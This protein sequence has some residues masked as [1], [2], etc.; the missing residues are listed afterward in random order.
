M[1]SGS[2]Q[3]KF[4]AVT[5]LDCLSTYDAWLVKT[6]EHYGFTYHVFGQYGQHREPTRERSTF[7]LHEF[8]PSVVA[9]DQR[10]LRP[11][12][13]DKKDAVPL[14]TAVI[15]ALEERARVTEWKRKQ[16][17]THVKPLDTRWWAITSRKKKNQHLEGL[18]SRLRRELP[19]ELKVIND[20]KVEACKLLQKVDVPLLAV[21]EQSVPPT[22]SDAQLSQISSQFGFERH[23]RDESSS[24]DSLMNL[25]E[26]SINIEVLTSLETNRVRD[27]L[28]DYT[29]AL[30]EREKTAMEHMKCELRA[31]KL[32]EERRRIAD[33]YK[34]LE[35]AIQFDIQQIDAVIRK[36]E[37]D[38]EKT[39]ASISQ[40]AS[41]P[42]TDEDEESKLVTPEQEH[43]DLEGSG[44]SRNIKSERDADSRNKLSN[45]MAPSTHSQVHEV[46]KV[47]LANVANPEPTV[48]S[49]EVEEDIEEEFSLHSSKL[50]ASPE[51]MSGKLDEKSFSAVG[52]LGAAGN[53]DADGYSSEDNK[54][55]HKSSHET[56]AGNETSSRSDHEG[57]RRHRTV[58]ES[59]ASED[60]ESELH[61]VEEQHLESMEDSSV[62]LPSTGA[63]K[64]VP[65]LQHSLYAD[66]VTE[67]LLEEALR[68]SIEAVTKIQK[69]IPERTPSPS[70]SE[71]SSSSSPH[72]ASISQPPETPEI[73]INAERS[74]RADEITNLLWM[75]MMNEF[76]VEEAAILSSKGTPVTQTEGGLEEMLEGEF[77]SASLEALIKARNV[78]FTAMEV[79]EEESKQLDALI[80]AK[81]SADVVEISAPYD[82]AP[83]QSIIEPEPTTPNIADTV[84]RIKRDAH[85]MSSSFGSQFAHAVVSEFADPENPQG[86]ARMPQIPV[87]VRQALVG[88][89][90][91][92]VIRARYRLLL[93][94]IREA[95]EEVFEHHESFASDEPRRA[96]RSYI[97]L[98][99]PRPISKEDTATRVA[100]KVGAWN[101]YTEVHGENLDPM[102][103]DSV[104][105]DERNWLDINI[106][107][108]TVVAQVADGLFGDIS[109]DALSI[110]SL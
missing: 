86:Y 27:T 104:I 85:Y 38:I 93:D 6:N 88:F 89:P 47:E 1:S 81:T 70:L 35:E 9:G 63:A 67:I 46:E 12:P 102:L 45:E 75:D 78:P 80:A 51:S 41:S 29:F 3:Q 91:D 106:D 74:R 60:D 43:T 79:S 95:L 71:S 68:D 97:M 39:I 90:M 4:V 34:Q 8:I 33:E 58:S 26:S 96:P 94:L 21:V 59:T 32:S 103:M 92:P 11:R 98:M 56:G 73:D 22:S 7:G 48:I 99:P 19:H 15:S 14:L 28:I 30:D 101:A 69:P 108:D 76:A 36:T 72:L 53:T 44:G 42:S 16:E 50:S 64:A 57:D 17:I 37:E 23:G 105:A 49:D 61:K 5:S 40:A 100:A 77:E 13:R 110:L 82:D 54:S 18:R 65:I 66:H 10:P 62:V 2:E 83:D 107:R 52:D 24:E 31:A 109:K 55:L 25:D 84:M 87:E 20:L